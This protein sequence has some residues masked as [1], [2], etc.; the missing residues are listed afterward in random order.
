MEVRIYPFV[1]DVVDALYNKCDKLI[2][3]YI[4]T[5]SEKSIFMMFMVMYL[6]V[7]LKLKD[8]LDGDENDRK[9]AVKQILSEFIRN[10][11]KRQICIQLF[12]NRFKTLFFEAI[13]GNNVKMIE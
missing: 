10:P 3:K 4:G 11:E 12:E 13:E 2:D 1:D 5:T 6:A 7:H 8:R 9:L